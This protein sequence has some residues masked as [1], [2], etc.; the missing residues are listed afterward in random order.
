MG[1]R[2]GIEIT[3]QTDGIIRQSSCSNGELAEPDFI[4]MAF[5]INK[6]GISETLSAK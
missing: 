4:V 3:S 6:T 1:Q 5:R 2:E